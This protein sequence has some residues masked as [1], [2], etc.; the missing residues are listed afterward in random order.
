MEL[1]MIAPKKV[2]FAGDLPPSPIEAAEEVKE[3]VCEMCQKVYPRD[4]YGGVC[5]Y[6]CARAMNPE[7]DVECMVCERIYVYPNGWP[8][9]YCSRGCCTSDMYSREEEGELFACIA[10]ETEEQQLQHDESFTCIA[11]ATVVPEPSGWKDLCNRGCYYDM[12]DLLDAY[13]SGRVDIPDPRLVE[14][15][16]R[17]PDGGGHGFW[18]PVR[19]ILYIRRSVFGKR[20]RGK[21]ARKARA[22]RIRAFN[23]ILYWYEK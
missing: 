1:A 2:F 15:F 4:Q 13:E 23:E 18:D 3:L 19:I 9:G 5:S 16:T 7:V 14:Y 17:N 11:C 22:E 12:G 8:R 20:P 6:E 10:R 21:R